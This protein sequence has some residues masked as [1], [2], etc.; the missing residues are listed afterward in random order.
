[1]PPLVK[2]R[3]EVTDK[4]VKDR[5]RGSKSYFLAFSLLIDAARYRG[6]ATYEGVAR[7]V[8]LPISGNAMQRAVG[9]LAGEI[10]EDE[11]RR[12]RPMLS[13][14]VVQKSSGMPGDGFF[15]LAQTLGRF[16][17]G[18]QAAKRRFWERERDSVYDAWK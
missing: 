7:A 13:A 3:K 2:E 5:Y 16:T 11:I 9:H 12:G 18:S 10:S 6:A 8:G 14:L 17:G 15:I 1:M 4:C